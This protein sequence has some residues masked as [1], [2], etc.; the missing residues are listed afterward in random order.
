MKRTNDFTDYVSL[1]C[2]VVTTTKHVV[3]AVFSVV[4][5]TSLVV[6]CHF[7]DAHCGLLM[8]RMRE[9]GNARDALESQSI[10]AVE[11][12]ANDLSVAV[13]DVVNQLSFH[14]ACPE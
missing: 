2:C 6:N 14:L 8:Q 9:L 13:E 3:G 12:V 10:R 1:V 11:Q 4:N 5:H 7:A